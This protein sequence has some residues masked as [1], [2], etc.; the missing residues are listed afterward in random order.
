[1]RKQALLMVPLV[2]LLM[3][4]ASLA[5]T[6]GISPS[7]VET[8]IQN[9]LYRAHIF[10][11]GQV[12]VEVVNGT[13]A[14]TGTVDSFGTKIDAQR[15]A[16]KAADGMRV[17]NNLS[18]QTG[19]I[20]TQQILEQAR[21]DVVTYYAYTIFDGIQL[22]ADGNSLVLK[23]QVTQP[24]KKSDLGNILAHIKGVTN[25]QNDLEVLPVSN[26]DDHLRLSIARAIYRDPYFIHYAVQAVPPIHIIVDNG[27]VTLEGVVATKMDKIKAEMAARTAAPSFAFTNMLRVE[28]S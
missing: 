1:M 16:E 22:E 21:K 8:N 23:G 3:V 26:F 19:N 13:A 12:Q 28:H 10:K 24:Y 7:Q 5:D 25:F 17:E 27:N 14:L 4:S 11:H 2:V 6:Q 15:A 9:R 18:V 20:S